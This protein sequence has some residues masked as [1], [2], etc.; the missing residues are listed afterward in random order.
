MVKKNHDEDDN[1][2]ASVSHRSAG[3]PLEKTM[4]K[5]GWDKDSKAINRAGEEVLVLGDFLN[6]VDEDLEW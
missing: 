1:L 6:L 3:L 5:A 4:A 2:S